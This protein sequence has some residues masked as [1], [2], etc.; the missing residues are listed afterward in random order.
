MQINPKIEKS[1]LKVLKEEFEKPYF[2]EIKKFLVEELE[3][4]K[5]IYPSAQLIFNAFNSTPFDQVKVVIL[6][7]DPYHGPNQAHGLCFSVQDPT[8][9]PPSLKNIYKELKSDLW[10]EPVESWNLE[11]WTKQW[12]F[13]LN[14]ILTVEKSKAASHSKI[15]WETF[16]DA[17][18]K[19]ISD[20]KEWVV[21]LLWWNFAKN[22]KSLI[23]TSKHF[24]LESAHPSPFSA[25]KFLWCKHFSKANEILRKEGKEE[26]NWNLI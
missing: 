10:I 15:W 14:A 18:I 23:D 11:K 19:K 16:T 8:P 6:G 4:W 13:L 7:Q 17:V 1:W 24:V 9:P 26:I 3:K 5:T 21:F 20:E 25:H 12:V 2:I 22:K